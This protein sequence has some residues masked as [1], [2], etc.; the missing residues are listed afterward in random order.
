M[1]HPTFL[2]HMFDVVINKKNVMFRYLLMN[3][4]FLLAINAHFFSHNLNIITQL[5]LLEFSL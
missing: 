2:E 5:K 4:M 1:P 3:S